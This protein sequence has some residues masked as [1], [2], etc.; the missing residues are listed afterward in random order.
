V[1]RYVQEHYPEKFPD[2]SRQVPKQDALASNLLKPLFPKPCTEDRIIRLC[3]SG[4][5]NQLL[6]DCP[7]LDSPHIPGTAVIRSIFKP[8]FKQQARAT[9]GECKLK[10][11]L[12]EAVAQSIQ[13]LPN[14]KVLKALWQKKAWWD[15]NVRQAVKVAL[16][17]SKKYRQAHGDEEAKKPTNGSKKPASTSLTHHSFKDRPSHIPS[18]VT[19]YVLSQEV[20]SVQSCG[21]IPSDFVTQATPMELV[22]LYAPKWYARCLLWNSRYES[23]M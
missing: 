21:F 6:V 12:H 11:G 5:F 13:R 14:T 19:S 7:N 8:V 16:F 17:D 18:S 9:S 2:P 20:R 1:H 10:E 15:D 22:K 4:N 23:F 3:T